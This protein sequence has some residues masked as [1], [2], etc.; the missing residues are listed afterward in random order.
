M[1]HQSF[2]GKTPTHLHC[3]PFY[4]AK[5]GWRFRV[6]RRIDG[7]LTVAGT[8]GT[9]AE[10]VEALKRKFPEEAHNFSEKKLRL[11]EAA[12][13]EPP[14]KLMKLEKRMFQGIYSEKHK[15]RNTSWK[16]QR[17]HGGGRYAT[18]LEAAQACAAAQGVQ[19]ADIKLKHAVL[20]TLPIGRQ[21]AIFVDAM[22]LYADRHPG[23]SVS[24]DSFADSELLWKCFTWQPG[25]IP[26]F[27]LAKYT[28]DRE[29]VLSATKDAM[30][31][32]ARRS[33][34]LDKVAALYEILVCAAK[35][36]AKHR[37]PAAWEKCVGHGNFHWM[38]FHSHAKLNKVLTPRGPVAGGRGLAFQNSETLYYVCPLNVAVR[39]NLQSQVSFGE[40]C[41]RQ[42]DNVPVTATEFI[43]CW[44]DVDSRSG[45]L[46]GASSKTCYTRKWLKRGFMRSL[47]Q[48]RGIALCTKG[49]SVRQFMN[50]FPDQHNRVL[51][52]LS[53]TEVSLHANLARPLAK[54]LKSLKYKDD[55]ELFSMHACLLDAFEVQCILRSKKEGWCKRHFHKLKWTMDKYLRDHGIW[56]HPAVLFEM[57]I[58]L[59]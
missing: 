20:P 38:N 3:Q 7:K 25:I 43:K 53:D 11:S 27:F 9:I 19:L 26:F 22:L 23:D 28:K 32:Y 14:E 1:S 47:M 17:I 33:K 6:R 51:S 58:H 2:S 16:V 59:P 41:M 45:V 24:T 8:H 12:T 46:V 48:S 40:G 50:C 21:Q 36:I 30:V 57:C 44:D 10:C 37:W 52:L 5:K 13:K 31:A 49:I 15:W 39:R 54:A 18:Q 55:A 56:P 29:D 35:K 42:K 34:P 4:S